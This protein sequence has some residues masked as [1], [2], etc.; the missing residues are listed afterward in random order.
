MPSWPLQDAK[1]R[2]SALVDRALSDGPQTITRHGTETVVVVSAKDWRALTTRRARTAKELLLSPARFPVDDLD[3]L[4]G[5]RR[6][7][8]LSRPAEF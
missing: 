3:E 2:L 1:Q 4:I 7:L 5:P 8:N 6:N